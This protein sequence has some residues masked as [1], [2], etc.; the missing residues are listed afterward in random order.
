[1][2]KG[3]KETK[4]KL[5]PIKKEKRI[6]V[7]LSEEDHERFREQ[8]FSAMCINAEIDRLIERRQKERQML[9]EY[10][11]KKYNLADERVWVWAGKK[12][13]YIEESKEGGEKE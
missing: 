8:S 3:T 1:M 11:H 2:T 12:E 10:M 5:K 6:M 7:K 4:L 13:L 9:W